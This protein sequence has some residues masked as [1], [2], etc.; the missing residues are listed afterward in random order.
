MG[1]LEDPGG[2]ALEPLQDAA[3]GAHVAAPSG[4]G[5]VAH[6]FCPALAL[7]GIERLEEQHRFGG[8]PFS[9]A[10]RGRL[11][12][13]P[14]AKQL[15]TGG[16]MLAE[17]LDQGRSVAG[18][19]ARQ[20]HQHP[21]GTPGRQQ[22]VAHGTNDLWRQGFDEGKTAG[23]PAGMP[24]HLRGDPVL[25][26][27]MGELEFAQQ[28]GLLKD[29]ELAGAVAAKKLA[30]G[31]V[32]AS[33]PDVGRERVEAGASGGLHPLVAVDEHPAAGLAGDHHDGQQLSLTYQRVGQADDLARP[34]DAGIGVNQIQKADLDGAYGDGR[35]HGSG[36]PNFSAKVSRV[37]SL[38]DGPLVKKSP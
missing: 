11:V 10:C 25:A 17:G 16:R 6:G 37:V 7:A 21:A 36:V 38:Q 15:A 19:G 34:P 18:V 22:P 3:G 23:D 28:G 30:K 8:H 33:G 1:G 20:W 4:L 2:G 24:A 35:A 5:T 9:Q 26:E 32:G 31:L 27:P 12:V 29:I 13:L 14:E